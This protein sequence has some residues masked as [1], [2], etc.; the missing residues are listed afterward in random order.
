MTTLDR[1][2]QYVA[3]LPGSHA[4]TVRGQLAWIRQHSDRQIRWA[5][6]RVYIHPVSAC[7][8]RRFTQIERDIRRCAADPK[9]RR[10]LRGKHARQIAQAVKFPANILDGTAIAA[11][12]ARIKDLLADAKKIGLHLAHIP[13]IGLIGGWTDSDAPAVIAAGYPVCRRGREWEIDAAY[14]YSQS[15]TDGETEW[16]NG[17]PKS[18]TRASNTTY[19]PSYGIINADTLTICILGK[20]CKIQAPAGHIWRILAGRI[21]L[22]APDGLDT[23][24]LCP[25]ALLAGNLAPV[26]ENLASQ[27]RKRTLS[28][29]LVLPV[30]ADALV[31]LADSVAAGN[32]ASGTLVW[33]K[34]H[35]IQGQSAPIYA[36]LPYINED[37]VKRAL[38]VATHRY[39]SERSA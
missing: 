37:R 30:P 28:L 23:H 8:V 22:I 2:P 4:K 15:H 16:R 33:G 26:L 17:V 3:A 39:E 12:L 13:T 35:A 29:P 7:P 18:Y 24:D 10:S 27:R 34:S 32:C 21:V 11:G 1:L 31:T 36:L 25:L 5:I 19:V 38:I 14:T 20:S 9:Y 6:Q